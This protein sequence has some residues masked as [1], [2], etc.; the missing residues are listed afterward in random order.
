[1]NYL[2]V[3]W[4]EIL[5][6]M[7]KSFFEVIVTICF[8]FIPFFFLSIKW[9]KKDGTNSSHA[10]FDSF[11]GYWEAGEIV[12]P[13]LGLCGAVVALLALNVGYFAWWI[14]ALVGAVILVFTFGGGAALIGTDG[15]KDSLNSELIEIGFIGYIVLAVIW[16]VLA[17]IVRGTN[18]KTRNSAKSSKDV[19]DEANRRRAELKG[20]K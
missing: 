14:H 15:F 12:L 10:L 2:N 8:T 13:I 19:L 20:I 17:S 6:G 18:P 9:S 1:M 11:Q 7:A 16:F 5:D 3:N 4:L